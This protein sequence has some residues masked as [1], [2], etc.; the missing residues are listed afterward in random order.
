MYRF[1][2]PADRQYVDLINN[3][4]S[5]GDKI[6]GRNGSTYRLFK[7][8]MAFTSTPLIHV[9]K[10][11]WKSALREMEWFLSGSN[12]LSD[13]HPTVQEWWKPWTN[14]DGTIYYN[15]GTQLRNSFGF[16]D[17]PFD[18]IKYLIDGITEHPYSRRLL[19]TTWNNADMG[20]RDCPITNCHG[21]VIHLNIDTNNRLNLFM[22]QRSVDAICG[23]P[24]NLIQYWAF[25]HWLA[26]KTSK[27]VGQFEWTGGDV[28]IYEQHLPLANK[29][30]LSDFDSIKPCHLLYYPN[31]EVTPQSPN[32]FR[33]NDFMLTGSYNPLITDKAEMVV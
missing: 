33:A 22:Y 7:V 10:T 25:L 11:A 26:F 17:L 32:D 24:H 30:L 13:L 8:D 4:L 5:Y 29:M 28:H 31:D 2:I 9:R 19:A 1:D 23:L 12:K 18:S 14:S 20:A 6:P 3:I 15:Y 21:T 16:S 27:N